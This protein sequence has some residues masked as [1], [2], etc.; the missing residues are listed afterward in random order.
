MCCV[1][2]ATVKNSNAVFTFVRQRIEEFDKSA[3]IIDLYWISVKSEWIDRNADLQFW[4]GRHLAAASEILVTQFNK[5]PCVCSICNFK[6]VEKTRLRDEV[7]LVP[8]S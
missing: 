2:V 5:F 7:E 8:K 4:A 3:F 1:E 6:A